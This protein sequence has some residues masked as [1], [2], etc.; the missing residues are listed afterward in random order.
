M[1]YVVHALAVD[2]LPRTVDEAFSDLTKANSEA[3]EVAQGGT[4]SS[5]MPRSALAALA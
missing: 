1:S 4:A 3:L 5:G 2:P